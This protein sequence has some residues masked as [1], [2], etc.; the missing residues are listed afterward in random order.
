MLSIPSPDSTEFAAGGEATKEFLLSIPSPD[1]TLDQLPTINLQVMT[2]NSFT[3]FHIEADIL[4][5]KP[6]ALAFNSFTGFHEE[7]DGVRVVHADYRFQFLHRIPPAEQ[8]QNRD[9]ACDF[10]FLHRIPHIR[11]WRSLTRWSRGLSI[12][13][14]DS[15]SLP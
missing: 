10:Q 13:S 15:T 7:V 11:H 6:M 3:G 1:S 2:F 8:E 5:L 4:K 9:R 12:P 14:P